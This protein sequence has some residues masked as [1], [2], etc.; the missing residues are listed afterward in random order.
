MPSTQLETW[1][2]PY[3]DY[4]RTYFKTLNLDGNYNSI[5]HCMYLP[6]YTEMQSKRN[7]YIPFH[8]SHAKVAR[9]TDVTAICQ[10]PIRNV[11]FGLFKYFQFRF[12][13]RLLLKLVPRLF[14]V[15]SI[16]Y[17]N[18]NSSVI[19]SMSVC[20]FYK[21]HAT[22]FA[23][24]RFGLSFFLTN[25]STVSGYLSESIWCNGAW[26]V[27][28]GSTAVATNS[29]FEYIFQ[30]RSKLIGCE[31]SIGKDLWSFYFRSSITV[32]SEMC[33][34][35]DRNTKIKIEKRKLDAWKRRNCE[36]DRPSCTTNIVLTNFS[37]ASSAAV[38][39]GRFASFYNVVATTINF[40]NARHRSA[41]YV[42]CHGMLSSGCK[43]S[44]G[45]VRSAALNREHVYRRPPHGLRMDHSLYGLIALQR[46][47]C[48]RNITISAF[49]WN[50]NN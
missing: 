31:Q 46:N 9:T 3:N 13:F 41:K 5:R 29:K 23:A 1:L 11:C 10:N 38:H 49:R 32:F 22:I 16:I 14:P 8:P 37:A 30:K 20:N 17:V 27:V 39:I 21:I 2:H 12:V 26:T 34:R 4:L 18:W 47:H 42:N 35:Q 19:T 50:H 44:H 6:F 15:E 25:F 48:S 36:D 40:P 33:E 7:C 24:S 45:S 43:W 28:C